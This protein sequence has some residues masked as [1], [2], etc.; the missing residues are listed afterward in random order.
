M[1]GTIISSSSSVFT[2][3]IILG[4]YFGYIKSDNPEEQNKR[5]KKV[6]TGFQI[7][8]AVIFTILTLVGFAYGV[9]TNSL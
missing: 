9:R 4:L 3:A 6:A 5:L 2:L 8:G 1:D 7:T